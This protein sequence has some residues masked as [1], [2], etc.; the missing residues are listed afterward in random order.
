MITKFKIFESKD[1]D[2]YDEENWS[3]FDVEDIKVGNIL[4]NKDHPHE[5]V[6]IMDIKGN[7]IYYGEN[8]RFKGWLHLI[9]KDQLKK[10][11]EYKT[12]EVK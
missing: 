10:W 3:E 4:I 12:V 6:K 5:Q 11:L 8:E 2:P 1:I 9:S 7:A